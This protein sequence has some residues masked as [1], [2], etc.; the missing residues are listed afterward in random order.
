MKPERLR[1]HIKGQVQGV[2]FRPHACQ[3]ARRLDLTGWV[4]N[5]AEGV[6]IEI[7]GASVSSFLPCLMAELPPLARV[8]QVQSKRIPR[9]QDEKTFQIIQSRSGPVNTLISPDAGICD[10]CLFELFDPASRYYLYPFLN[11]TH[12][13]PRLTI[14]RRL[15]YDRHHTSMDVFPL[16]PDCRR[17]YTDVENRR[18]HAQPVACAACGPR[19]THSIAQAAQYLRDGEIIALKGQ[20]GYQL[21][22]DAK[23]S[24]TVRR[25]REGKNREAKPLALMTLNA[26]SASCLAHVCEHSKRLLES[27]ERPIVLLPGRG[28]D[29]HVCASH[30][31]SGV[32]RNFLD[33]IAP[34]LSTIGVMLP[35]TPLYYLM[36]HALAGFPAGHAWLEEDHPYVLVVTSANRSGDPLVADD[37]T[38]LRELCGIAD[39]IIFYNREIVCRADDS[40]VRVIDHAP[41]FIRRSRG[42]VPSP[43]RLAHALPSTLALGG[44]LKN[45]FC[46]TRADEAFVSPYIGTLN[47]KAAIDFFHESLNHFMEFLDIRPERIAHDFHPDFYTTQFAQHYGLPVYAVQHHHAH[48]AAVA[49]EQHILTPA[50]GL[51]L[52]GYGYGA[53]GEAWGGELFLLENT[54]CKRLGYLT[55]LPLPGGDI[56]AREPWRMAASV[57]HLLGRGQEIPHRFGQYPHA[58]LLSSLLEKGLNTSLTSSGGRLF[59]AASGILGV[60]GVSRYEGQAA[61]QLESLVTKP[62]ILPE[63][64]RVENGCLNMLPVLARLF[65]MDPVRGANLFHGTL[66]AGMVEWIIKAAECHSVD[67]VLLAGG[68][69]LNKVLAEGL[70]NRLAEKGLKAILP[71]SI[72]PNDGG[73]SLGQAWIAGRM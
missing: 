24:G 59:D 9:E 45:T 7:Q 32:S 49:A 65:D 6:L 70:I 26:A 1:I 18:Y 46:L 25:L 58:G 28:F 38:A 34:G 68:C 11:C 40:V 69:F 60:T 39:R 8:Y 67:V 57:L 14:T 71:R 37:Q 73:L 55:P 72:P 31:H 33:V 51:A 3:T 41:V 27:K 63:G 61:M 52:D 42:Y 44:H 47:N 10:A 43:V 4:Q 50:L 5:N 15:P 54:A 56:A 22:C 35:Y 19:L 13:G 30:L 23:N 16:C 12:C 21:I 20:G 36:F 66:T 2:G 29:S 53:K 48:L 62:V 64:W 17:D